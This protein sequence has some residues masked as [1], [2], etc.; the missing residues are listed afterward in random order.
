[1]ASITNDKTTNGKWLVEAIGSDGEDIEM[2]CATHAEAQA[3]ANIE[4]TNQLKYFAEWRIID[5]HNQHKDGLS[6]R[7]WCAKN[8]PVYRN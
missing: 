1:M 4:S 2:F 7:E 5:G 6:F 3:I 8:N